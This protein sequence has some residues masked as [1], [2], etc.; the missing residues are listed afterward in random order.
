VAVFPFRPTSPGAGEWSEAVGDLLATALDGTPGVRVADPWSLWQSL[1]PER[2]AR[3]E[4]PDPEEADRLAREAHAGFFLLGSVLENQGRLDLTLR[5]YQAGASDALHTLSAAAP[6]ESLTTVAQRLAVGVIEW[7]WSERRDSTPRV[8][9]LEG[10]TTRVPAALKAYLQAKEAMR[11]GQVDEANTAIDRALGLDSAFALA[12]VE[13]AIIKSW[14]QQMQG[15]PF[16]GLRELVQRAGRYADSLSPRNQLRATAIAASIETDGAQAAGALSRIVQLDS[17]DFEAWIA[18][19]YVHQTYGW[20]Y[21]KGPADAEAALERAIRLDPGYVPALASR[22]WVAV[23]G[24]DRD[25]LRHQLDRLRQADS[26]SMLV[27][28]S[29]LGINALL[30]DDAGFPPFADSVARRMRPQTSISQASDST[31]RNCVKPLSDR[32]KN[33]GCCCLPALP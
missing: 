21:R 29:R 24:G 26:G 15:R 27:R 5:V 20:Q 18:L 16:A 8:R 13:A 22:A 30:R 14:W 9:D 23:A 19:A 12:L 2:G 1:R 3:A 25:D 31:P 6:A 7:I 28:G 33:C 11:R 10:Y 4:A 32:L 17:T